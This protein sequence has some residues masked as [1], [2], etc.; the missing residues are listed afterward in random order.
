MTTVDEIA[1]HLYGLPLEEFTP[2]R[3][4]AAKKARDAGDAGAAKAITALRKPTVVG[5]LANQLAREHAAELTPLLELGEAL[6]EATADLDGDQ[7]RRL[8]AQQH[9][10]V[11]ALVQRAKR[12][13]KAAGRPVSEDAARGLEDTLHA[14]LADPA[15]AQALREGRLTQGLSR[16]GFPSGFSAAFPDAPAAPEAPRK[17][18]AQP[19]RGAGRTTDDADRRR[20][21]AERAA[22]KARVEAEAAG[23]A[24]E[25]TERELAEA[26]RAAR[27]AQNKVDEYRRELN[28]ARADQD[29]ADEAVAA[30]RRAARQAEVAARRAT[31]ALEHANER[32]ARW[33]D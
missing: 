15:A 5:W 25:R 26:E 28:R 11:H 18:P 24:R 30:A 1:D 13:A 6:R 21:E 2:A 22:D 20:A 8:S 3:Q 17:E 23:E 33:D 14:A 4:A 32:V 29:Q 7:L 27:A 12:T 31:A 9:Q 10:V 19:G 16:I